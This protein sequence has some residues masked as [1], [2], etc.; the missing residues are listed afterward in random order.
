M[1]AGI[2]KIYKCAL[3]NIEFLNAIKEADNDK[4]PTMFSGEFEKHMFVTTYYGWLVGKYG[5]EWK[6]FV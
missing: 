2:K 3:S 6:D 5:N 4:K 1:N